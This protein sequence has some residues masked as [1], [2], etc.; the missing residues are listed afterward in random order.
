[1]NIVRTMLAGN[2]PERRPRAGHV[3]AISACN[4]SPA[5]WNGP[6]MHTVGRPVPQTDAWADDLR[7]FLEGVLRDRAGGDRRR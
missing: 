6:A 5:G 7:A 2:H 3:G 4:R 1:M